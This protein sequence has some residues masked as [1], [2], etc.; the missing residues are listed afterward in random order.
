MN[1]KFSTL[2]AGLAMVTAVSANAQTA[3][4]ALSIPVE[5]GEAAVIK[6]AAEMTKYVHLTD[7]TNVLMVGTVDNKAGVIVEALS[8]L[9]ASNVNKALWEVKAG[10]TDPASGNKTYIFVNK[11]TG[12]VLNFDKKANKDKAILAAGTTEWVWTISESGATLYNAAKDASV[13]F[14][15]SKVTI[16]KKIEAETMVKAFSAATYYLTA[17][18]LNEFYGNGFALAFDKDIDGNPFTASALTAES[19]IE[20]TA[21]TPKEDLYVRL[22]LQGTKKY[23]SVDTT[24]YT[25]QGIHTIKG[26]DG[27]GYKLTTDTLVYNERT[28]KH[29]FSTKPAYLYDFRFTL[30]PAAAEGEGKLTIEVKT[31]KVDQ[32]TAKGPKFIEGATY[33]EKGN[34]IGGTPKA[35]FEGKNFLSWTLFEDG[36]KYLS[37]SDAVAR[38]FPIITFK[39]GNYAEIEDGAYYWIDAR[40]YVKQWNTAET[41]YRW[42][43]NPKKGQYYVATL[44]CEDDA[45]AEKVVSKNA[46]SYIASTQWAVNNTAKGAYTIENREYNYSEDVKLYD[47]GNNTYAVGGKQDTIKLVAVKDADKFVGY[48]NFTEKETHELVF[49]LKVA[50]GI[51]DAFVGGVNDKGVLKLV[52]AEELNDETQTFTLE[53]VGQ[54]FQLTTNENDSLV[55][56]LY[57]LKEVGGNRYLN[58]DGENF[59]LTTGGASYAYAFKNTVKADEYQML[60][61]GY[62]GESVNVDINSGL[63][64]SDEEIAENELEKDVDYKSVNSYEDWSLK[65]AGSVSDAKF[66]KTAKCDTKFADRFSIVAE[67]KA[68]YATLEEGHKNFSTTEDDSKFLTMFT[69]GSAV[70]KTADQV[71]GDTTVTAENLGLWLQEANMEDVVKPLYYITTAR[72]LSEEDQKAGLKYYMVSLKDSVEKVEDYTGFDRKVGFVLGAAQGDSAL[73]IVSSK[74]SL[75]IETSPAAV[76]FELTDVEGYYRIVLPGLM[77]TQRKWNINEETNSWEPVV[78]A[79]GDPVYEEVPS[80]YNYLA[81]QNNVLYLSSKAD[82]YLFSVAATENCPTGNESIETESSI[83]VIAGNG[84]IEIQGAAGKK[85]SV[86]NVL[87]K[88]VAET[89]L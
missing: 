34:L 80:N 38:V 6:K 85:V 32:T 44:G 25:R 78:D 7:G 75:A 17:A 20:A 45:E 9:D 71:M 24:L 56:N 47:L 61:Y 21:T 1:K 41:E 36:S 62:N 10:K 60:V 63:I 51:A 31:P 14:N 83:A 55:Y 22:N 4:P 37:T 89:V 48:K 54:T 12:A 88:P 19:D 8:N 82:A 11:A 27:I 40:K 81:V 50:S 53:K 23:V 52:K 16:A 13:N 74:D 3:E 69:D 87:G 86:K 35:A 5:G 39:A 30:D 84:V 2:L 67:P 70:L 28:D 33:D 66:T 65:A 29:V 77:E 58:A 49:G 42:I 43:A 15:A 59:K 79:W 57:A 18:G 64:I 46:Y 68:E 26:D 72:G 73:A 76:A